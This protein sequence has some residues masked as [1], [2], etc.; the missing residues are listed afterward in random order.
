MEAVLK[1]LADTLGVSPLT[2][3]LIAGLVLGAVLVLAVRGRQPG[4]GDAPHLPR[5]GSALP[6]HTRMPPGADAGPLDAQGR[7]E[8]ETLLDQGKGIEAIK[9][10]RELTGLGLKE[11]KDLVDVFRQHRS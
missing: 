6:F 5:G 7:H 3:A 11:A 10:V 4:H 9:R 2:L 1:P 8:V